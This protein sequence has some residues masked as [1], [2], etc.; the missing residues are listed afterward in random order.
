[1]TPADSRYLGGAVGFENSDPD[2]TGLP[3]RHA[4]ASKKTKL[5]DELWH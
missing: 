1:M 3:I 5:W 4:T 2:L